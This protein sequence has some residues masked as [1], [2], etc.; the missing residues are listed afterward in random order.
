MQRYAAAMSGGSRG[1][2]AGELERLRREYES[3][4]SWRVTRPLRA[5]GRLGRAVAGPRP[6]DPAPPPSEIAERID[7]WLE[8]FYGDRLAALDQACAAGD[9]AERFALFRDLDLDLWAMLLSQQYEA[10]ANIRVLLPEMPDAE[11]QERWNGRSGLSL[12]SQSSSFY[13]KLIARY[14]H[15]ARTSVAQARVLDFGCGWGRVTR[16]LARDVEPGRL[17]GCD[18]VAE[19]LEVCRANRVPA[20]LARSEFRPERIPFEEPFELA[21]AFSVFTHLS[22]SAHE[23]CLSALHRALRP[24]ALLILTIRPPAY[25]QRCEQL[26]PVLEGLGPDPQAEL[27]RPRYLFAPHAGEAHPQYQGQG[28]MYY[29]ETV[30]TLAYVR[31]RWSELFELLDADLLIDDPFQVVLTLRR[32]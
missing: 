26:H 9:G 32:R 31:E 4:L 24:G 25:L 17:Y 10:F 2:D 30:I 16:F 13:A 19:I 18:P 29:G 7:S 28:E 8:H 12:A 23:C 5:A 6:S 27:A 15:Y 3:S 1:A 21:F 14:E 11:L 22:E 20:T